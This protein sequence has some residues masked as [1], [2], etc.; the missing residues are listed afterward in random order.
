V[1]TECNVGH[2]H[3]SFDM[4]ANS[5]DAHEDSG[6]MKDGITPITP[7]KIPIARGVGHIAIGKVCLAHRAL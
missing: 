2:D 5:R 1:F 7:H 4:T 3:R 6:E